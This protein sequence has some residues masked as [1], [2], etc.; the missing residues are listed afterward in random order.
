[1]VGILNLFGL[2]V[3]VVVEMGLVMVGIFV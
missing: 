3:I 1:M 2:K